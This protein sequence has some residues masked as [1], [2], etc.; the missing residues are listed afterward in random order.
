V[1]KLTYSNSKKSRI[2]IIYRP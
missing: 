1:K 2:R